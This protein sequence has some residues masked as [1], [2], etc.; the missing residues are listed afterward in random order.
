MKVIPAAL[1]FVFIA[2]THLY[3]AATDYFP[4]AVG[5]VWEYEVLDE[6]SGISSWHHDSYATKTIT[7][8][9]EE[10]SGDTTYYFLIDSTVQDSS[11]TITS[12]HDTSDTINYDTV[13]TVFQDST[14]TFRDTL[15]LVN[16]T[17]SPANGRSFFRGLAYYLKNYN[18]NELPFE[19]EFI[20]D[21]TS[22]FGSFGRGI[23]TD[24]LFIDNAVFA[25]VNNIGITYKYYFSDIM[26]NR[27]NT[28]IRLKSF[29]AH[30]D[31]V[32]KTN[33][34]TATPHNK[35]PEY[36]SFAVNRQSIQLHNRLRESLKINL[37]RM[38]GARLYSSTT[39]AASENIPIH[40]F[41]DG[42]FILNVE[43]RAGKKSQ[44]IHRRNW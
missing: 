9:D 13:K 22:L 29:T 30:G 1:I 35:Q 40:N 23:Y 26:S 17:I 10:L 37:Y 43:G 12:S 16:D 19:G 15:L 25:V 2:I 11:I 38:N 34:I 28:Y 18:I 20:G 7:V 39:S 41:R 36:I 44:V 21:T 42:I 4:L 33:A 32:Y 31:T 27:H 6:Y 5:N 3:S 14:S 24:I 8:Y